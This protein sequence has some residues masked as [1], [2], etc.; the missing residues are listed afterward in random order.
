MPFAIVESFAAGVPVMG[1][2][3]GGIPELVI[4]EQT[5]FTFEAG[6][7]AELTRVIER[8][9]L[10]DRGNYEHMRDMC[11]TYIRLH[12]NE[13]EYL[14]TLLSLYRALIRKLKVE[15]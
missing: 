4:N 1:S 5:G 14:N 13:D 3:T 11:K 12:C 9:A 10:L 2:D 6:S 8:V 15:K 7:V